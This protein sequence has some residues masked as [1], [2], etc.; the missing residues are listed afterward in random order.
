MCV[1]VA[2]GWVILASDLPPWQS[3]NDTQKM[4]SHFTLILEL[5]LSSVRET[6]IRAAS[7]LDLSIKKKN[8]P[9]PI[10]EKELQ[11]Q[12]CKRVSWWQPLPYASS[13]LAIVNIRISL[14]FKFQAVSY[15]QENYENLIRIETTNAKTQKF[16]RCTDA[17]GLNTFPLVAHTTTCAAS[18]NAMLPRFSMEETEIRL[19]KIFFNTLLD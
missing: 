13:W 15:C 1:I 17:L 16:G 14:T 5:E 12:M 4:F 11:Y 9:K 19:Q 2:R 10:I 8:Q 3:H 6:C 7:L 18:K